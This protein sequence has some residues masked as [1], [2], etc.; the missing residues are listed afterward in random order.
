MKKIKIFENNLE[1]INAN[2]IL[3]I[4]SKIKKNYPFINLD[5][6]ED[7]SIDESLKVKKNTTI[8]SLINKQKIRYPL[9][10]NGTFRDDINNFLNINSSIKKVFK[11]IEKE[12]NKIYQSYIT[13]EN[14]LY[15]KLIE[16][17]LFYENKEE[18]SQL[19]IITKIKEIYKI[20]KNSFKFINYYLF[21]NFDLLKSI[22]ENMDNNLNELYGVK[23]LSLIF[24]LKYFEFPN[25]ELGYTLQFKIFDEETLIL[26]NILKELKMQLIL[27]NNSKDDINIDEKEQN[28]KNEDLN[29][30]DI[31]NEQDLNDTFNAMIALME[32]YYDKSFNII[33]IINGI[34]S[35]RVLYTNYFM[36]LRAN[37][38]LD[39]SKKKLL[40]NSTNSNADLSSINSTELSDLISINSLMDEEVI[41]NRFLN[42]KIVNNFLNFF[43]NNLPIKY[44][45][46]KFLLKIQ[47]FKNYAFYPI[48]I[49]INKKYKDKI[50]IKEMCIYLISYKVGLI[51]SNLSNS[52]LLNK[53]I[54][55]KILL[56]LNN[57]FLFIPLSLLLLTKYEI[58][59]FNQKYIFIINRF[60][61]GLS[62]SKIIEA[63]FLLS[64]SP[65]LIIIKNIKN[66]FQLKYLFIF[67]SIIYIIL[68]NEIS[69]K[70]DFAGFLNNDLISKIKQEF[71][72]ICFNIIILVINIIF[73]VNINIKDIIKK[74]NN[75]ET[76]IINKSES[77]GLIKS[78]NI[79]ESNHSANS[80]LSDD[81]HSNLS[82]GKRK[83]ISYKIKR[84]AK[85]L[86]NRFKSLI[87]NE[88]YEGKNI[89]LEEIDNI[90]FSQNNCCSYLNKISFGLLFL[91]LFS[92]VNNEILFLLITFTDNSSNNF[93]I[94]T[95]SYF[96]GYLSFY[97]KGLFKNIRNKIKLS[98]A[99]IIIIMIFQI[100]SYIL[101][102]YYI[103]T[104]NNNYGIIIFSIIIMY[105]NIII[106]SLITYVM[107]I[108]IPMEKCIE[109]ICKINF[110]TF[111]D[112]FIFFVSIFN[113]IF[114]FI[115]SKYYLGAN[116]ILNNKEIKSEFIALLGIT[117]LYLL[118]GIITFYFFNFKINYKS[119]TRIMNK[120]TSEK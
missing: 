61:Y 12:I 97:F 115:I 6:D 78:L 71:I 54:S 62:N 76:I 59:N 108:L 3:L 30:L 22:F 32:N 68:I 89:I 85:I 81:H 5:S 99:I 34:Y 112:L 104:F 9:Y 110:G 105:S 37:Y 50:D 101:F 15:E 109:F 35:Y 98:N 29:M 28:L 58:I 103:L 63:K 19:Q 120:I 118:V 67:F 95:I 116:V 92:I 91:L 107:T 51:I 40:I 52:F 31:K 49:F 53:N 96:F 83:L 44:K 36:Y 16:I 14:I 74:N 80:D 88:N 56:L 106:E 17:I 33:K 21:Y 8:H 46:D 57:S 11:K 65:K 69:E 102:F 79:F 94:V 48:I 47:S 113:F 111:I 20:L 117:F 7:I 42:K 27:I 75:N 82:Y 25:N 55:L 84:K 66:F 41:I 64:Y 26:E 13:I 114:I 86:D 1:N 4:I 2:E 23:S 18:F 70:Y 90:I 93:R 77:N 100:I 24:L 43:E 72:F 119:L 38:N 45:I 39:E 87:N 10:E 73:F 60:F